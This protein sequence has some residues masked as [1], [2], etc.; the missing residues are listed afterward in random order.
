MEGSGIISRQHLD[1]PIPYKYVFSR[2]KGPVEYEFIYKLQKQKHEHVNRC[3]QVKSELLGAGRPR[4]P[5]PVGRARS[6]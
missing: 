1:K 5:S 4:A 2:A 6:P 3:L